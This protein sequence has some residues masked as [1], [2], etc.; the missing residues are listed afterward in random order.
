[1]CVV[2]QHHP[3]T[4]FYYKPML[5]DNPKNC[6][7]TFYSIVSTHDICIFCFCYIKHFPY[8]TAVYKSYIL[9]LCF[10]IEIKKKQNDKQ[11]LFPLKKSFDFKNHPHM[12]WTVIICSDVNSRKKSCSRGWFL[13]VHNQL[14]NDCKINFL[15]KKFEFQWKWLLQALHMIIH[16]SH[17]RCSCYISIYINITVDWM[18]IYIYYWK[19]I[20]QDSSIELK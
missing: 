3:Y 14:G 2:S 10:F 11:K 1:M 4:H 6:L 18:K 8:P 17:F 5:N 7:G 13:N 15:Q 20:S 12:M 19:F 16:L 9:H